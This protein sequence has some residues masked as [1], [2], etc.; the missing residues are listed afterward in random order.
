[1]TVT[2]WFGLLGFGVFPDIA[3]NLSVYALSAINFLTNR[4]SS[5]IINQMMR[6]PRQNSFN[7]PIPSHAIVGGVSVAQPLILDTSA[8]IDGRILDIAKT[9]FISG[10]ILVPTF[11]LEE[12]Q[13]VADSSDFLKRSRGRRGFEV[14]EEMK[15]VKGLRI[16]IWENGIAGKGVDEKLVRLAKSLHGKIITTDFN[17]NRVATLSNVMVLNVNDLANSV[18]TLAIPGERIDVKVVH[19]GKDAK[20]GVGYFPDGTMIVVEDGA[21]LVGK[22]ILVEVSRI[23]QVPAGRMV[24]AKRVAE[25]PKK[26]D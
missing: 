24:F 16:E 7:A 18:K 20:Q 17:L 13:Q 22:T 21:E 2:V 11:V 12:L 15:K 1:M 19:L 26:S 4:V 25:T 14:V 8:I 9:N 5:E 3:K 23:L 10:M 6:L